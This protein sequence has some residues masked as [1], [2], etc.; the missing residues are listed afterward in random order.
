MENPMNNPE[1]KEGDLTKKIEDCTARVPSKFY[2]CTALTIMG[3]SIF[4][5]CKGHKHIALFLGQWV[6]PILIMGVYN[7]LDK[8]HGHD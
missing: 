4:F 1:L 7:K 8:I 2:L 5:K 3:A 6:A